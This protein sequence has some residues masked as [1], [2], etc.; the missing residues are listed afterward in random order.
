MP[1]R[2]STRPAAWAGAGVG[3]GLRLRRTTARARARARARVSGSLKPRHAC[4]VCSTTRRRRRRDPHSLAAAAAAG[5][6]LQLVATTALLPTPVVT[7][8]TTSHRPTACPCRRIVATPMAP[9]PGLALGARPVGL[10]MEMV[11]VVVVVVVAGSVPQPHQ[12]PRATTRRGTACPTTTTKRPC[13]RRLF[14]LAVRR[15]DTACRGWPGV[16]RGRQG[17]GQARPP[18][19]RNALPRAPVLGARSR[20]H[21]AWARRSLRGVRWRCVVW[22]VGLVWSRVSLC[23][24]RWV[25]TSPC[26]LYLQAHIKRIQA[27]NKK[28]A[29]RRL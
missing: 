28:K 7:R 12:L 9:P 13:R 27:A 11:V 19:A 1:P 25:L 17:E 2:G 22:C 8:G 20:L 24:Y 10:G 18:C 3:R 5:F 14:L 26:V 15:W 21:V 23:R 4:T 6:L 16:P 29:S